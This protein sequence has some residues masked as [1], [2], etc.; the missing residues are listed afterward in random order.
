MYFLGLENTTGLLGIFLSQHKYARDLV[1]AA[2]LQDST[3]FDTLVKLNLKLAKKKV[4]C[5]QTLLP[6]LS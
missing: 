4:T 2:G 5:Y 1:D 6:I 3:L